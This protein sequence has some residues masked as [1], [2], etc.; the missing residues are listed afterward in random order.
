MGTVLPARPAQTL[1]VTIRR[2]EL[3]ELKN[4]RDQLKQELAQLRLALQNQGQVAAVTQL[5]A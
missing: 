3:R 4:E 5:H 2:D 1:Y